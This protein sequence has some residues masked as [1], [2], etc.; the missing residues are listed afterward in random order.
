[1]Q[2]RSR[3]A[4]VLACLVGI[5]APLGS[6]PLVAHAPAA[7]RAL[8]NT[9]ALQLCW[10]GL[11]GLVALQ[12]G[13]SVRDRLGLGRGRLAAAPGAL[14]VLG[15]L[16]FSGALQFAIDALDLAP[17]SALERLD[18]IAGAAAPSNP[19]LLL[20]AFGLAPGLGEELLLR[21]ALQCSLARGIGAWCVPVAALA[22]GALH[23]DPVHSPAAFALGCYLG[24]LAWFG[25]S[26]WIAI[27][28]HIANNVAA[29]LSQ[30][31]PAL[32]S[33]LPAPGSWGGAALWV[34]AAGL[35]LVAFERWTRP[36]GD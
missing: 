9:L 25:R 22:F 24:A 28:C 34:G 19:W 1:M 26:T 7:D 17:G 16:A 5:A 10:S 2:P 32:A 27:A 21:G 8:W 18:A 11:A 13:G 6:G 14:A 33:A 3:I 30:T 20:L 35:A 4:L 15:T 23:L 31:T 12:L 29:T 36:T